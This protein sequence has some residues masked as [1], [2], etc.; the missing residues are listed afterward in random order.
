M[1]FGSSAF[2]GPHETLLKLVTRG[3]FCFLWVNVVHCQNHPVKYKFSSSKKIKQAFLGCS[4]KPKFEE[5]GTEGE[6]PAPAYSLRSAWDGWKPFGEGSLP[7]NLANG[8]SVTNEV[9]GTAWLSFCICSQMIGRDVQKWGS[10][11]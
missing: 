2:S 7:G 11:W 5:S 10:P 9:V 1:A 4:F 6:H 8:G 3:A